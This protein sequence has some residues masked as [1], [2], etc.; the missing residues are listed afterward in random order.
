MKTKLLFV[1]FIVIYVLIVFKLFFLQ[2]LSPFKVNQDLYLQSRKLLPE[3]GKI[4]D[5]NMTPLALNQNSYLLYLEPKK[6]TDELKLT[7][8]LS[9]E[10]DMPEA[11]L[12]AKIDMTKDWVAITSGINEDKKNAIA[13]LKLDGVGF[14]EDMKRFYP[15]A[16][17]SA[18]L[19]GFVGKDKNGADT[20]YFGIEG[21]YN[22]DLSGLP[23]LLDSERDLFGRPIFIGVQNKVDPE[24]GRDLVLTIDKTVQEIAKKRLQE[25]IEKYK[26]KQGCVLIAD[27]Y[28]MAILSL[29][30]LPDY[31]LDKYYNFSE[32]YFLDPA[33]SDA[34]EPGSIFKPLIMA[35]AINE[36]KVQPQDTVNEDGPA[37]VS[38][39]KIKT[40]NDQYEG[41]ITMTR[42]LEKSSNVGMVYVGDRLGQD[43][44]YKYLEKY[45]FGKETGIDLQGEDPSYLKP[46]S[47]W[48]PIDFATV[49][50]GQGIAVTQIQMVRA[51]A[52]VINGGYLMKPYV[53]GQIRSDK[54]TINVQPQVQGRVIS[55]LTSDI[56]KKMLVS[57]VDNAE[58][59]WD[60]PQ[61]IQI[62]G[63][64]GTA[65]V[66]IQGHYDPN[67]TNASFIGFLPADKPK[68]IA[69]VTLKQPQTSPWGSETAA[70]I[71]FNIAKDL[72]VYYGITPSQ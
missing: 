8:L 72:I 42:I 39:Y 49:T 33:V 11:S 14:Q 35:A 48:Y 22:Q 23:G 37:V 31:D 15:E 58:V 44:I 36:K 10:L 28:T 16:S 50:F 54:E 38:G 2:I 4:Y 60:R 53:V 64:T 13:S 34:F 21:Y 19:L 27:P 1:G 69:L 45:G 7:K 40:W 71:F 46:K 24:N 51:F 41:K 47:D 65:Q 30:C 43:D 18:H 9:G 61:G 59:K 12:E 55:S 32:S 29:V 62:G 66:A 6:I 70:P 25:G 5:R 56:M 17:L 63:K 52:A 3:R 57:T 20:G 68:F 26:A 67:K